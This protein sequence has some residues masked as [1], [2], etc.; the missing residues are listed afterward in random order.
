DVIRTYRPSLNPAST[1][2]FSAVIHAFVAAARRVSRKPL[3]TP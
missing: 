3:C 2:A 1:H